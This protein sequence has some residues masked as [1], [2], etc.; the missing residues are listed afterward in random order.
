ME[1]AL[2]LTHD[3]EA[4]VDNPFLLDTRAWV[5]YKMGLYPEATSVLRKALAKA[6]D[7]PLMNYHFGLFMLKAGDKPMAQ[8]YLEIALRGGKTFEGFEDAR[9]LVADL[10]HSS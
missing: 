4:K 2:A 1:K 10:Q 5:Y 6:P 7:H 3:F 9:R 8:K